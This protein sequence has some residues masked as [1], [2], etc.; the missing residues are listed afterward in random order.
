MNLPDVRRSF[1]DV[2]VVGFYQRANL[3]MAVD[4]DSTIE[5]LDRT[6]YSAYAERCRE[7][8]CLGRGLTKESVESMNFNE[9]ASSVKHAW[10]KRKDVESAEVQATI[11][12][13]FRTRDVHSG[14]WM[15]TK[16]AKIVHTRQSTVLY[17]A[18]AIDYELVEPGGRELHCS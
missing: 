14:H 10:I 16:H 12:R 11:K 2:T 17:T 18:P 9:F 15:L 3:K 6:Q 5:Y 13:K 4:D 8:T 7:D 1:A